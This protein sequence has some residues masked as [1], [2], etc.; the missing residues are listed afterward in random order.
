MEV[1]HHK[2]LSMLLPTDDNKKAGATKFL[3]VED[4]TSLIY[5]KLKEL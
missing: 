4:L 3:L 2:K 1:L 5:K